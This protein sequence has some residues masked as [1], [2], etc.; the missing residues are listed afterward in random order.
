M[1][2]TRLGDLIIA[3]SKLISIIHILKITL[4]DFHMEK[5]LSIF[6]PRL[7][8]EELEQRSQIR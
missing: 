5:K 6:Y 4:F 8:K 2:R 7:F 1:N 3:R